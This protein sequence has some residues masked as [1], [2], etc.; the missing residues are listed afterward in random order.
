MWTKNNTHQRPVTSHGCP[1]FVQIEK[2]FTC[3]SQLITKPSSI[4]THLSQPQY[5][6]CNIHLVDTKHDYVF[7]PTRPNH[8][9][10]RVPIHL[11]TWGQIYIYH[12][13]NTLTWGMCLWYHSSRAVCRRRHFIRA[14]IPFAHLVGEEELTFSKNSTFH[15]DIYHK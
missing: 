10:H 9:P 7:S 2:T 5:F 1:K 6:M 14:I 13:N 3:I 11:L 15:T 12:H 8:L 4:L